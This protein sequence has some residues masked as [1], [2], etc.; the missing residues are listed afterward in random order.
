[1]IFEYLLATFLFILGAL[2]FEF[3]T[4]KKKEKKNEVKK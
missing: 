4:N 3:M 1:M 2:T